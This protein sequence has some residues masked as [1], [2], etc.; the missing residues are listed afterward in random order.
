MKL[1]KCLALLFSLNFIFCYQNLFSEKI[2][3]LAHPTNF[4]I[5]EITKGEDVFNGKL[6]TELYK[7]GNFFNIVHINTYGRDDQNIWPESNK[8]KIENIK[9]ILLEFQDGTTKEYLI[10]NEKNTVAM[11]K[12][13]IAKL[14]EWADLKT[15]FPQKGTAYGFEDFKRPAYQIFYDDKELADDTE[16]V[17]GMKLI[18]G[19]RNEKWDMELVFLDETNKSITKIPAKIMNL[20]T[21]N[22]LKY[23]IAIML[24]LEYGSDAYNKIDIQPEIGKNFDDSS[25]SFHELG[26]DKKNRTIYV[27]GLTKENLKPL[28]NPEKIFLDWGTAASLTHEFITTNNIVNQDPATTNLIKN[29]VK[30]IIYSKQIKEEDRP[31]ISGMVRDAITAY[32]LG[33][34]LYLTIK[35]NNMETIQEQNISDDLEKIATKIIEHKP[36]FSKLKDT[37]NTTKSDLNAL[38]EDIT[39]QII[40]RIKLILNLAVEFGKQGDKTEEAQKKITL[41]IFASTFSYEE[42]PENLANCFVGYYNKIIGNNDSKK[43]LSVFHFSWIPDIYKGA[44]SATIRSAPLTKA[45]EPKE[46]SLIPNLRQLRNNITELK[47]KLQQ[48]NQKLETLRSRL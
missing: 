2:Y 44:N 15:L 11:L 37:Y 30:K 45:N 35:P 19:I 31:F 33:K 18:F 43:I 14:K 1:N 34:L 13:D 6:I 3:L 17:N 7:D 21:V 16:L 10:F 46:N 9:T 39:P 24:G 47:T 42:L 4:I 22:W 5:G 23:Q 8:E 41:R 20:D 28:E 26:Y 12:D 29:F 48:L 40:E 25:K 27:K 36:E 38:L 32:L